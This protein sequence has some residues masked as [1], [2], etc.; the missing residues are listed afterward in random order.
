MEAAWALSLGTVWNPAFS[1]S[2][3]WE[4]R[5]DYEGG[6]W[7]TGRWQYK[8][9]VAIDDGPWMTEGEYWS[10]VGPIFGRASFRYRGDDR[11]SWEPDFCAECGKSNIQCYWINYNYRCCMDC[12][13]IASSQIWRFLLHKSGECAAAMV[14][15]YLWEPCQ[16]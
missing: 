5:W 1:M 3:V 11:W 6:R 4:K 2:E 15:E 8:W 7:P 14:W 13:D 12:W 16:H 9:C 10:H